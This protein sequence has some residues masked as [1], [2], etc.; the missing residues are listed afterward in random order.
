MKRSLAA[1]GRAWATGLAC[2]LLVA[3]CGPA[4]ASPSPPVPAPSQEP[5]AGDLMIGLIT[6]TDANPFFVTMKESALRR[7]DELDVEL[8]T[9]A[10]LYDG[11]SEAQVQAI[12]TLLADGAD[13]ILITPSAP[14]ALAEP[15]GRARDAGVLVIA[16]DTP[17]DPP[18][19]VDATFATDNFRAGEL[20]G[21]WARQRMGAGAKDARIATLDGSSAQVTVD[22]LRNQGFLAGFGIDIEDPQRMYDENDP[23]IVGS[24][25]TMGTEEG[26]RSAMERLLRER[27][28]INLVYAINEPAA[29]GAYAALQARGVAEDVLLVTIDGSCS[30]VHR[31]AAGAFGATAMQY[32]LRMATLG[33]EAVVEFY[34]TGRKPVDTP[35]LDFHDTGTALVTD[36]P[37]AGV[38]SIDTTRGLGECWGPTG[39]SE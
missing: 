33:V 12:E 2:T 35:G 11:D 39:P 22:V 25:A 10:G 16:L 28:A 29:A 1:T 7:A 8:R 30:G 27:P 13:G 9:F 17:F 5:E 34:A 38:P 19:A 26:G 3:R 37:V 31:V 6:K 36:V 21:L 32:P 20:V 15:V 14:A 4:P 24:S 18:N 23:R